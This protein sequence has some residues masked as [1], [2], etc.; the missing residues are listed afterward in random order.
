[1]DKHDDQN[2]VESEKMDNIEQND[3]IK[4]DSPNLE[5]ENQDSEK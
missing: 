5:N 1:M 4:D 3:S 2:P